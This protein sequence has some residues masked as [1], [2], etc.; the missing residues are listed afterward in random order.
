MG[1]AKPD[2][3][4]GHAAQID[5]RFFWERH[6]RSPQHYAR[7]QLLVLGRHVAEHVDHLPSV[8]L[9]FRLLPNIAD[10]ESTGWKAGF[11]GGVLGMEMRGGEEEL[12]VIGREFGG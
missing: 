6:V 3:P 1:F 12:V 5:A 10:K 11:T 4:H 8:F 9:H 7:E 2:Q